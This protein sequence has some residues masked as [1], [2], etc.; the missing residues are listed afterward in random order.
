MA[1]KFTATEGNL[2][3]DLNAAYYFYEQSA[4]EQA[5][6]WLPEEPEIET[7][8][9][10]EPVVS[11]APQTEARPMSFFGKAAVLALFI[12]FGFTLLYMTTD[13]NR[14]YAARQ[15]YEDTRDKLEEERKKTAVLQDKAETV[16]SMSDLYKDAVERYGMRE[17][18]PGEYV[19]IGPLV[20][21]YT[22]QTIQ[23]ERKDTEIRIHWFGK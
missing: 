14:V 7:P 3:R 18:Q 19:V 4:A 8:V 20:D 6:D 10:E 15:K 21:V 2:A 13:A 11:Q 1:E 9:I 5:P 16:L 17:A 22:V 23:E 12:L